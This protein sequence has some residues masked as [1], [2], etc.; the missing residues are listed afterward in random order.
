VSKRLV[1]FVA[2]ASAALLAGCGRIDGSP[3]VSH[4]QFAHFALFAPGLVFELHPTDN[5]ILVRAAAAE[6]LKVCQVGTSF[7][8]R[9]QGGCREL[10][11]GTVSLPATS[12]AYHVV[13]RVTTSAVRV[14]RVQRLELRWHCVDH[15]LGILRGRTRAPTARGVF[16]C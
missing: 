2:T 13:F 16:D 4:V 15:R 5:R 10:G 9:W 11:H 1:Y 14:T 12:G 7:A 3:P 6:P 8:G